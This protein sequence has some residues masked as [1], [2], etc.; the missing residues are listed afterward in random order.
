M[1]G[2]FPEEQ[3]TFAQEVAHEIAPFHFTASH[4]DPDQFALGAFRS[5][6]CAQ[7]TI[8]FDDQVD[9]FFQVAASFRKGSA[10]RIDSGNLF[11]RGD[12]P[13]SALFNDGGKLSLGTHV[14]LRKCT[15]GRRGEGRAPLQP[16]RLKFPVKFP[17]MDL[18]RGAGQ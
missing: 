1:A 16:R 12:I 6:L 10:L 11:D 18:A 3:A 8:G 15:T 2:P 5:L 14:G 17:V 7:F 9:C 13:L 4:V